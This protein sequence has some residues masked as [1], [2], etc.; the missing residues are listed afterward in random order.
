[1][2]RL[3]FIGFLLVT[4]SLNVSAGATKYNFSAFVDLNAGY[5]FN[6]LVSLSENW[7]GAEGYGYSL[8]GGVQFDRLRVF[9][10]A[11]K[12]STSQSS[13]HAFAYVKTD[14]YGLGASY[15]PPEQTFAQERA[16][17]EIYT[18][19]LW[20]RANTILQ[21][22]ED[23]LSDHT[24]NIYKYAV[25]LKGFFHLIEHLEVY[26]G[27]EASYTSINFEYPGAYG[28]DETSPIRLN[29]FPLVGVRASL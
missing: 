6:P 25:G 27:G 4:A 8:S 17:F 5:M 29:F 28:G 16:H 9:G 13:R 20:G 26:A 10:I 19:F 7:D 11:Q 15:A 1:M 18:Y 3:V 23:V 14:S 21:E 2:N 12:M 24:K 22:D